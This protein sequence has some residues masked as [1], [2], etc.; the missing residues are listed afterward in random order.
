MAD[1]PL[2]EVHPEPQQVRLSTAA[3]NQQKVVFGGRLG[4]D[5]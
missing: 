1:H 4:S 3:R 2:I 5:K